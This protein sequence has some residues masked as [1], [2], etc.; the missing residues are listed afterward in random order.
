M[1]F[2]SGIFASINA[3]AASPPLIIYTGE[4]KRCDPGL[5][6]QHVQVCSWDASA[7]NELLVG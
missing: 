1:F 5:P 2:I 4:S 7:P 6:S 3:Q